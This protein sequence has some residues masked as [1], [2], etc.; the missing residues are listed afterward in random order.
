MGK[1]TGRESKEQL[2]EKVRRLYQAV[3]ELVEEGADIAG[4]KV[5]D[6]TEKAG[7][8]KGTAYD[9]FDTKEE[10]IVYALL[11]DMEESL[12]QL[13]EIIWE[14]ETFAEQVELALH[15]VDKQIGKGACILRF[16]NLL[17]D[18]SQTG[19]FL[20]KVLQERM[21]K[22][23]C[24]PLLFGRRM[25]ER[26]V[27]SGELRDDLPLSYMAYILVTKL[28][29]YLV[30]TVR[31]LGAGGQSGIY[32]DPLFG[33]RQLSGEEFRGYILKGMLEEFGRKE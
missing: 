20:R 27:S 2:P 3:A 17:L 1:I 14:K 15:T 26:A 31:S 6:I 28:V 12:T 18:S 33:E 7:I 30:Y 11:Y 23:Q 9:Y 16:V 8:G 5:S 21:K 19:A 25:L 32:T 4:L 10:I 24:E 13:E 29:A 22:E